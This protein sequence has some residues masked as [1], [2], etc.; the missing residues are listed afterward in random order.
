MEQPKYCV[1]NQTCECFLS[2]GATV[3]NS[4]ST[5]T[6]GMIGRRTLR[7]SG[8]YWVMCPENNDLFSTLSSR[9]LVYLDKDQ[10]VT[11]IVESF[12]AFRDAQMAPDAASV[13]VL[14][15][16]TIYSS[17]TQP[18]DQLII[19]VAEE[20]EFWLTSASGPEPPDEMSGSAPETENSPPARFSADRR[21]SK[22]HQWPP[23]IAY[24]W[25]GATLAVN[26]IRDISSTGLYLL[27]EKFWPLG[28]MVMLTLQRTDEVDENSEQSITVR[29]RVARWEASGIG[30]VFDQP[31]VEE[32]SG[33]T[34]SIRNSG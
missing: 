34:P 33:A 10:R 25:T 5:R 9:D 19:R 24:D 13:L 16:H 23:L 1:Y 15:V 30:L 11:H 4:T 8:D 17:Q 22:R 26:G 21:S 20:M 12:P 6:K 3:A 32:S 14:P 31:E 2:L 27:T 18:G 7:S 28:T 29:L